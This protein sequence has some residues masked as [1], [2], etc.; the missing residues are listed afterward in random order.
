MI[1]LVQIPVHLCYTGNNVRLEGAVNGSCSTVLVLLF[2][3]WRRQTY[4]Y[5]PSLHRYQINTAWWQRHVSLWTACQGL[6][7]NPRPVGCKSSALP[8]RHR[9]TAK[10]RTDRKTTSSLT[11]EWHGHRRRR[12]HFSDD[13]LEH[14][15]RQK[16]RNSCIQEHSSHL[17]HICRNY[18]VLHDTII[19]ER[20]AVCKHEVKPGDRS[21]ECEAND[22]N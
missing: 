22:V 7:P 15:Q 6:H 14:A 18:D 16:N 12:D 2:T 21:K 17:T 9:V 8:V 11:D 4:G 19:L 1:S 20:E 10:D 13:Q 5:L 3:L